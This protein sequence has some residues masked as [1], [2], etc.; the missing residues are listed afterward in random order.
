MHNCFN[1]DKIVIPIKVDFMKS[2]L[3]FSI[4]LGF[5]QLR[6]HP[7]AHHIENDY[8]PV[9]KFESSLKLKIPHPFSDKN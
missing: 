9:H 8:Q 1:L 3:F 4:R 6:I 2:I 5:D 7:F